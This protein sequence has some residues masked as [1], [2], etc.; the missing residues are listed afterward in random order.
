MLSQVVSGPPPH[1]LRHPAP[2][3]SPPLPPLVVLKYELCKHVMPASLPSFTSPSPRA[4][5]PPPPPR[6][7]TPYEP[8]P[9]PFA[10][11]SLFSALFFG[12][13]RDLNVKLF[14]YQRSSCQWMLDH[15]RDPHGLNGYFWERRCV[16]FPSLDSVVWFLFCFV[17]FRL[18]VFR[19]LDH[20][21]DPHGLNC[22][23]VLAPYP[24]APIALFPP[25]TWVL[26]KRYV[27]W[28]LLPR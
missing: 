21:G 19:F 12:Q 11:H 7:L 13:P 25:L 23:G 3:L 15:E 17:L 18:F 9:H 20:E 14:D 16:F 27:A 5:P 1:P 26:Y 24:H 6:Y 10:G 22:C 28:T 4:T 2:F 8:P